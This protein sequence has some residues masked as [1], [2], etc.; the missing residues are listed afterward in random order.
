[1][2]KTVSIIIAGLVFLGAGHSIVWS[3][4]PVNQ[5]V[6]AQIRYEGFEHSNVMDTLWHLTDVIGPRLTGTPAMLEANEWTKKQLSNWGLENTRLEGFDF[7]PGW[8]QDYISVFMTEPRRTQLYAMPISWHPGTD[9]VLEGDIFYAPIKKKKDFKKY[10]GKLAGKI[11]LVDKAKPLKAPKNEVFI[12]RTD[13]DL[14][15]SESYKI[16]GDDDRQDEVDDWVKYRS[17]QYE[18]E[19]F[20]AKE[21]AVA[22]VRRSPR[23]A[24]LIEASGYQHIPGHLPVI[25]AIRLAA[26]HYNRAIRLT[27]QDISVKLSMDVR[28]TFHKEDLRSYSTLADIPG[29]GGSPEVV[30]AGAHLD[31]WAV[32]DGAVDNGAGVAVVMEAVRI[33]KA[34]GVK[35]KRTIRVGLWGGE[36]QGYYGSQQYVLDH[37]VTRPKNKDKDLQYMGSYE[38]YYNQFPL[39]LKPDYKKFSAYFNLDNGSGRIRGVF[40]EGNSS[41]KPIF[42][43][44]LA[45]F[46]DVGATTFSPNPTGGTDHEPFDDIG[47]PAFQFIQDPLDYGSRLHHS[48]I[49]LFDHVQEE[50]LRQASVV[51]ASFL[52]HAA[53]R[54]ERLPRKPMPTK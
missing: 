43:A 41:V 4:E 40:A 27:E 21:G 17:F 39:K 29:Q 48:Q 2:K 5:D 19:K 47:L 33:L 16:P 7:G 12:R 42:E 24:M 49:D 35:P 23:D 54:D 52:Y 38:Q 30:L 8:T 36:E 15:K 14:Q 37:L 46:H 18:L 50:D 31:S 11:V 3:E 9:G 34:I 51:L 26:E 53:M 1:M 28:V 22:M 32:A 44:W 20:L 45:P 6:I 13:E 10:K 25:P